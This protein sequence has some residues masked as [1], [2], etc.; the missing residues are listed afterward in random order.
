MGNRAGSYEKERIAVPADNIMVLPVREETSVSSSSHTIQQYQQQHAILPLQVKGRGGRRK[1]S[2]WAIMKDSA[3]YNQNR[4]SSGNRN[5]MEIQTQKSD[6]DSESMQR[7]ASDSNLIVS[8]RYGQANG[9][10]EFCSF[11]NNN[12][13]DKE[14]DDAKKEK[15]EAQQQSKMR[16]RS[17]GSEISSGVNRRSNLFGAPPVAPSN[18][19]TNS[20][21]SSR[22]S[23]VRVRRNSFGDESSVN[24]SSRKRKPSSWAIMKDSA[25]Y[26]LPRTNGRTA[27]GATTII[28][29]TI[30]GIAVE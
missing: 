14:D 12:N 20:N 19:N 7:S 21:G 9:E 1:P 10:E 4:P 11:H 3:G 15:K 23:S 13:D 22:K 5:S 6:Q 30:T 8:P 24:A 27:V 28:S 25:G 18:S 16:R 17:F 29:T 2:A 26:D